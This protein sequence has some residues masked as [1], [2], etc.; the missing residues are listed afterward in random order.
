MKHLGTKKLET[1]RLILRPFAV[2]D[3]QVMFDQ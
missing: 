3:A 2:E 1:S